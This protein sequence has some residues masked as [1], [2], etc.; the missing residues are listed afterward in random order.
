[1][2]EA[3]VPEDLLTRADEDEEIASADLPERTEAA[4][5]GL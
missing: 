3:T 1:M 2:G 5:E 4:E